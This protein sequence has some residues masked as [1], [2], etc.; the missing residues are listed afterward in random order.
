MNP[1][2]GRGSVGARSLRS[3]A[4]VL[5]VPGLIFC[6][7]NSTRATMCLDSYTWD[8]KQGYVA[9]PCIDINRCSVRQGSG[10]GD[11]EEQ[12]ARDDDSAGAGN[13]ENSAVSAGSG[14]AK[15]RGDGE[16]AAVSTVVVRVAKAGAFYLRSLYGSLTLRS[17]RSREDAATPLVKLLGGRGLR[18]MGVMGVA[19]AVLSLVYLLQGLAARLA[20]R[21]NQLNLH[22]R[23]RGGKPSLAGR[24]VENAA[25]WLARLMPPGGLPL[26]IAGLV[27]FIAVS[28]L[29]PGPELGALHWLDPTG[30]SNDWAKILWAGLALSLADGAA[31]ILMRGWR[32]VT[33]VEMHR[34]YADSLRMWG[35][36]P[37][38]AVAQVSRAVRAAQ[39]RGGLLA[40]L[41]GLLVVEGVFGVDGLG[42]TLK[43]LIVDRQ[44]LDALLLANVLAV[45][46]LIVLVIEQ[47]P[48]EK[49]L[50]RR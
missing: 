19:L 36:D 15:G 16:G 47:I 26:P 1:G 40:L 33:S 12:R 41:G 31:S 42:E 22:V 48:F 39:L 27:V 49:V 2:H 25:S 18:S 24:F 23:S 37:A 34:S 46:A 4:L 20:R 32:H 5:L 44:G 28:R 45:F 17:G 6:V 29:V 10:C 8:S 14:A 21:W 7:V 43:D 30:H 9:D 13:D 38:P 35:C 11:A 50:G 3:L